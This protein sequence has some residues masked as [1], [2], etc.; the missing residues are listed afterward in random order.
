LPIEVSAPAM[1][2]WTLKNGL[3]MPSA[4]LAVR[5]MRISR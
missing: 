5:I 2:S 4:S 1:A 3:E